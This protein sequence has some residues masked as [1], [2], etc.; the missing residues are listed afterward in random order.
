VGSYGTLTLN[1][2]S[3]A[4]SYQLND[5]NSAVNALSTD[6]TLTETFSVTSY[7]GSLSSSAENL[8]FTVVGVND[9]LSSLSLSDTE[10]DE[11]EQAAIVASV[12][13]VD[14][15]NSALTY[16]LA[17]GGDNEQFEITTDGI[18]KFKDGIAADFNSQASYSISIAVSDGVHSLNG[19]FDI[20]VTDI[21]LTPEVAISTPG[22][23]IDEDTPFS[24]TFAGN[25]FTDADGE[26][27]SV[28]AQLVGGSALP[29]WLSFD[30]ENL[31]LSGTPTNDDVGTIHISAI[32]TDRMGLTAEDQF[33]ITV[34]NV[35]DAPIFTAEP[36]LTVSEDSVYSYS[37]KVTDVDLGDRV[38]V[39]V[40]SKPS[41]LSYNSTL[42]LLSGIPTNSVVGDHTVILKAIDYVG[43]TTFKEFTITVENVNDAPTLSQPITDQQFQEASLGTFTFGDSVFS[44]IDVGDTLSYSATLSSGAALPSWLTFNAEAQTFSGT[45]TLSDVGSLDL[46]LIGTDSGGLSATDQF[47]IDISYVNHAPVAVKSMITAELPIGNSSFEITGAPQLFSD[48]DTQFGDT[49]SYS[50]TLKDG[51]AL[52]SWLSVD[53]VTGYLSG[54]APKVDVREN[55]NTRNL[56]AYDAATDSYDSNGLLNYETTYVTVTATDAGGLSVTSDVALAP[57]ALAQVYTNSV[58]LIDYPVG[59]SQVETALDATLNYRENDGNVLSLNTFNLDNANLQLAKDK[60]G[61]S[62]D[63]TTWPSS[64]EII[65]NL[66][67]IEPN[68]DFGNIGEIS[69]FLG[70]VKNNDGSNYRTVESDERYVKLNFTADAVTDAQGNISFDFNERL[71]GDIKY[72]TTS[73][74]LLASVAVSENE[75]LTFISGENGAPDKLKISVL[76]LLDQLPFNGA[77]GALVPFDVG[78]FYVS[79]DGIPLQ[80]TTGEFVDLIDAQF[81]II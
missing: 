57:K 53:S 25:K 46:V 36:N 7:D 72:N 13:A 26:T 8:S 28:S 18:L 33:S 11:Y 27:L 9:A 70:E 19:D 10:V 24:L 3:G 73:N 68:I 54:I 63:T 64:P 58:N 43:A 4:Y 79:I 76:D 71:E 22:Q 2:I 34:A 67:T 69:I 50:A 21:N 61:S 51:S 37:A 12:L 32:A 81:N 62:W 47:S 42:R 20:S 1:K 16:S 17:S 14:P 75:T 44:D 78:A 39:V 74:P 52:P 77:V 5:T 48:I 59:T 49:L 80:S 56:D 66:S 38:S 60:S 30:T 55:P 29:S 31:T 23:S 35:N 41:W 15:E 45:P 40:E 6:E 65:I